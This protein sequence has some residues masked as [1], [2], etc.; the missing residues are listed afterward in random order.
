MHSA[1]KEAERLVQGVGFMAG[2]LSRHQVETGRTQ[3][4]EALILARGIVLYVVST[5]HFSLMN[6]RV[7]YSFR[8]LR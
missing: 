3:P 1:Y 5:S 2:R 4:Y 6:S 8:A 7:A